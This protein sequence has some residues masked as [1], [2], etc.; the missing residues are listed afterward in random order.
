M[1]KLFIIFI[2]IFFSLNLQGQLNP[3]I[4]YTV[5]IQ[6][7]TGIGNNF[8]E[9]IMDKYDQTFKKKFPKA[10]HQF[11][12]PR[13][14]HKNKW[15]YGADGKIVGERFPLSSTA[16]VWTTDLRHLL[17]TTERWTII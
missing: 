5:G 6:F 9:N 7:V 1:K 3:N 16:L 2:L 11:T 8:H 13:I 15:R 4:R 14:S 17:Q 12:D 10:N